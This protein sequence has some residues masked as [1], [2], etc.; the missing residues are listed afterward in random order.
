LRFFGGFSGG[1][2]NRQKIFKKMPF[3]LCFYLTFGRVWWIIGIE[4]KQKAE[5]TTEKQT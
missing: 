3:F 4:T 5:K 2:L 1:S